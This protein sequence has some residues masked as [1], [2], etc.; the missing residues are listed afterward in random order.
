LDVAYVVYSANQEKMALA[1]QATGLKHPSLTGEP[2]E[3]QQVL[4]NTE[5]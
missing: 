1:R 2:T 3:N 5:K 4:F